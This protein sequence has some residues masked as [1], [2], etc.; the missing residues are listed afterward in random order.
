M[1]LPQEN[2]MENDTTESEE[3]DSPQVDPFTHNLELSTWQWARSIALAVVLAPIRVVM[4]FS[5]LSTA[6]LV[7]R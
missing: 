2:A 5:L 6:W 3:D 4:V 1:A 7:C